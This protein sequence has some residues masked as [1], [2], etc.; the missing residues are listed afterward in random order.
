[1]AA[2]VKNALRWLLRL[3]IRYPLGCGAFVATCGVADSV[4]AKESESLLARVH[5]G[6][7]AAQVEAAIAR[8][9]EY[10]V[11]YARLGEDEQFSYN[12]TVR[13]YRLEVIFVNGRSRERHTFRTDAGPVRRFC[14]GE[15]FCWLAPLVDD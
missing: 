11:R 12:W 6:M 2:S 10:T 1:M 13:G 14:G 9:P 4:T 7:T 5:S 8:P 15:F 3:L